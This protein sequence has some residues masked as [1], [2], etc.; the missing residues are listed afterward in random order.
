V[1]CCKADREYERLEISV[2]S[3]NDLVDVSNGRFLGKT[4]LGAEAL[5]KCRE[6]GRWA[7]SPHWTIFDPGSS[8][9]RRE[10][11]SQ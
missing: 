10:I 3:P 11:T 2:A 7:G 8:G 9:K 1:K 4:D 6:N 5:T